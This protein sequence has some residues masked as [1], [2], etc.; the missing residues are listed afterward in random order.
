M[1]TNFSHAANVF[2]LRI[3]NMICKLM[4]FVFERIAK[5]GGAE[6]GSH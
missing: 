2:F 5:C 6:V 3:D 1:E 4:A